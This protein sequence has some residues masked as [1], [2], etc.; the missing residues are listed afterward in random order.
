MTYDQFAAE[1]ASEITVAFI[2]NVH[3]SSLALK[4]ADEVNEFFSKVFQNI[5][6]NM[7]ESD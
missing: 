2:N 3:A 7:T 4:D 1:K 5:L 6:K